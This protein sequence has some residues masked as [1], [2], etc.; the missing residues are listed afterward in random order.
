MC[1]L[2]KAHPHPAVVLAAVVHKIG[3]ASLPLRL[4]GA[5]CAHSQSHP[6][7][8]LEAVVPGVGVSSLPVVVLGAC[9]PTSQDSLA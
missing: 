1:P 7:L 5:P 8:Y 4:T 3:A 2:I 9:V 6:T